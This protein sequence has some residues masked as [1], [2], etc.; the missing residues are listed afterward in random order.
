MCVSNILE[1]SH[2]QPIIY[3]SFGVCLQTPVT[4]M[5]VPSALVMHGMPRHQYLA[6]DPQAVSHKSL[7]MD[8]WDTCVAS[9]ILL[10][11]LFPGVREYLCT[12][13]DLL[14]ITL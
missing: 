7:R 8:L 13:H 10:P 6:M 9:F 2:T 11:V 1:I 4:S 14:T 3:V 5:P 12:S